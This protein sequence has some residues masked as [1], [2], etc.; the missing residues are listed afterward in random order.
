MVLF[1]NISAI[2]NVLGS[3]NNKIPSTRDEDGS[4]LVPL[5]SSGSLAISKGANIVE[6]LRYRVRLEAAQKNLSVPSPSSST[7]AGVGKEKSDSL[8]VT[9]S[10]SSTSRVGEGEGAG[11]DREKV[12]PMHTLR[13]V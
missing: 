10:T 12:P 9:S 11:R 5:G 8:S 7:A 3:R 2:L 6:Q 4:A 1:I 13:N